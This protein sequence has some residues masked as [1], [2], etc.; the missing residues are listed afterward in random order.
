MDAPLL[1]DY[2]LETAA[3]EHIVEV[4]SKVSQELGGRIAPSECL[5][6]P[7]PASC[8]KPESPASSWGRAISIRRTRRMNGWSWTRLPSPL[9]FMR[10]PSWNF[11]GREAL[12][13]RVANRASAALYLSRRRLS[14]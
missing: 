4:V 14:Q 2:P 8:P 7:M 13:L 3:S 11:D 9:K 10:A 1:E 6:A 12:R 5:T